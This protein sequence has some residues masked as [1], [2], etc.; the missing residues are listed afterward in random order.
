[1]LLRRF[2]QICRQNGNWI[3]HDVLVPMTITRLSLLLVG[4]FS[5]Y[6]LPNPSFPERWILERGWHFSPHR[7]LDI[8]GRWDSGWYMSIVQGGYSLSGDIY[9]VQSNIAFFPLYPYLVRLLSQLV[10]QGLRT[11]GALLLVGIMVSN[12]TLLAALILLWKLV[13]AGLGDEAVAQR[14][15]L[16]T[17]V[18][19]TGFFLSAFYAES[20]FLFLA[21]AAFYCASRRAWK[22]AGAAGFFLSLTRPTGV[23]VLVPMVWMYLD[24]LGWDWRRVRRGVMW[25]LLIPAGFLVFPISL[26]AITG[27][28]LAII[29]AQRAWGRTVVLPWRTIIAPSNFIPYITPTEQILTIGFILTGCLSLF[30]LPSASYGTFSLL[31]MVPILLSG[32][33]LSAVRFFGVLFPVFIVLAKLGKCKIVD[34]LIM[35]LSITMQTLFMAAWCQFYWVG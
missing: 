18:F 10:P 27:D 17:L 13:V 9:T 25:L 14:A 23:L 5:L 24:S 2:E 32:T 22:L 31:S 28:P 8:W 7:L 12:A 30:V 29:H 4:W 3:W 16:Y 19:P 34:R 21:V 11:P 6:F 1:M 35:V 26:Y 20:L 15:V 33:L